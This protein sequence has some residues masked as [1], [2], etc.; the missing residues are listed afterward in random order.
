MKRTLI[1]ITSLAVVCAVGTGCQQLPGSHEQQG[2]VIGGA[3]GAIA[4]AAIAD[5]NLL[6]ALIGGAVGATGGYL[7]GANSDRILG[8][9]RAAAEKAV[10]NAQTTP[11]TPAQV[12][13]AK[14]AD[15]NSDG[16]VTMDEVTAM[17]AAGLTDA[18][19]LAR[20]RA[21]DQIFELTPAQERTLQDQGVSTVVIAG[22]RNINRDTRDRLL[23]DQVI[24][25]PR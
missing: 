17:N 23:N 14:T 20:L 7:L 12:R 21:T 1:S 6:G 25:T 4:G 2:A 10:Q 8:R 13:D 18:Q 5:N 16:F 19:M 9:D 15:I 24:G 22:M 3:G 11:A